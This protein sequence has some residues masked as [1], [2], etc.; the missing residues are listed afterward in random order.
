MNVILTIMG[1]IVTMIALR[2]Q[3]FT[4]AKLYIFQR[5][6]SNRKDINNGLKQIHLRFFIGN[7]GHSTATI[8]SIYFFKDELKKISDDSAEKYGFQV[9]D[10]SE[11]ESCTDIKQWDTD[12]KQWDINHNCKNFKEN[13]VLKSGDVKSLCAVITFEKVNNN[14]NNKSPDFE[15]L[16]QEFENNFSSLHI[17]VE[18]HDGRKKK[19]KCF[20]GKIETKLDPDNSE[21]TA[22]S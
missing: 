15:A 21:D 6:D 22:K 4:G 10:T 12:I 18:Y 3:A 14:N 11:K 2:Y 8:T 19:E 20:K 7:N 16:R 17:D 13:I 9:K 5:K 1:V